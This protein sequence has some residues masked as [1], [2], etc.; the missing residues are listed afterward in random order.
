M[1]GERF[2][3]KAWNNWVNWTV[4]AVLFALSFV[5]AAQVIAPGLF[6]VAIA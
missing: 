6:S 4:I 5:L 1:L 2:V 3:N